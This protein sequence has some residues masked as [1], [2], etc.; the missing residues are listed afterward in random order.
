MVLPY[1]SSEIAVTQNAGQNALQGSDSLLKLM[2]LTLHSASSHTLLEAPSASNTLC[3]GREELASTQT[4]YGMIENML[5]ATLETSEYIECISVCWCQQSV[6]SDD[7]IVLPISM[8]SQ[9]LS[10]RFGFTCPQ[11]LEDSGGEAIESIVA[12]NERAAWSLRL[13]V[14]SAT[15]LGV[16]YLLSSIDKSYWSKEDWPDPG[17]AVEEK[18]L[19]LAALL[20][21]LT[22]CH[23]CLAQYSF[24]TYI[25]NSSS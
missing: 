20:D 4:P 6:I 7:Q 12:V 21:L 22:N 8:V 2:L 13:G 16:N 23:R 9:W 5:H 19:V 24:S 1:Q 3:W 10:L 14:I 15:F 25:R 17:A 18:G 11:C